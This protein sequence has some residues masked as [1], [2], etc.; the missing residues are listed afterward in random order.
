MSDQILIH[1]L[2]YG[3]YVLEAGVCVLLASRGRW[4][5]LKGLSLY[6]TLLFGLDGVARPAVLNYFG[7]K[8]VQ[9]AY[10]YWLTDVVLA[11]GAFLLI[12]SF[13]R[14][15][16]TQEQKLWRFVRLLLVFVF[17]LVV[18]ISFLALTRHYSQLYTRFIVEFSQNLY[19][20]CLVLNTLL[21]VMIQQLAID[22]DELGL[23]VC[24]LG[25]QFA[26]EAAILALYNLT[27]GE[28]F[29]RALIDFLT[30]ACTLGM[31]V[32]W[33]YAISKTPQE[34][35]VRL[36]PGRGASLAEVIADS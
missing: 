9:F 34:V 15:A 20:S 2:Q 10:F 36:Q 25:V 29:A 8:S 7:G 1:G 31:L 18:A 14:R 11:M 16:C 12:C 4:W 6:V 21:Y 19:F 28:N 3:I 32:I 23:L 5:H 27:V 26:G 22:D 33:I 13:F 17:V 35:P 30:P 24:G